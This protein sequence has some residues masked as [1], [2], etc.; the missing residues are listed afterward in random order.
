MKMEGDWIIQ[1]LIYIFM[2]IVLIVIAIADVKEKTINQKLLWILLLGSFL[3]VNRRNELS[4]TSAISAT[5]SIFIL[6][7]FVYFISHKA[8]GWGDVKLCSCIAPYL[9]IERAFSM[10]FIAIFICGLTALI[11]LCANKAN[12]HRELPFAPFAAIGTMVVLIF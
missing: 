1:S 3:A 2:M 10:F 12:K 4:V 7:S 11:L 6:L 8:L 5:A 9:G